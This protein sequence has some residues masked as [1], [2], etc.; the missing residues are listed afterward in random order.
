MRLWPAQ[1]SGDDFWIADEL[2]RALDPLQSS[3]L[4]SHRRR[5]L[6]DFRLTGFIAASLIS[7][8][9]IAIKL[10]PDS[11]TIVERSEAT[12]T[13]SMRRTA[14]RI[15]PLVLSTS[16]LSFEAIALLS[17]TSRN[18]DL[19]TLSL[20]A[21]QTRG[22]PSFLFRPRSNSISLFAVF[23]LQDCLAVSRRY[24]CVYIASLIPL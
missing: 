4:A 22:M 20:D 17:S 24:R 11:P 7:I 23:Y 19:I 2:G 21:L 5:D 15:T 16:A 6:R 14:R 18:A 1:W 9:P 13:L 3:R 8:T 12:S 10:T